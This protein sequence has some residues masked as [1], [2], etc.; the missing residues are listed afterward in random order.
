M[1]TFAS[2]ILSLLDS[3]LINSLS[4]GIHETKRRGF[5]KTSAASALGTP[6][7]IFPFP[8][9]QKDWGVRI[10]LMPVTF[11]HRFLPIAPPM[12]STRSLLVHR[13]FP[14]AVGGLHYGG[15][16]APAWGMNLERFAR[17]L[18]RDGAPND[19]SVDFR[20][21]VSRRDASFFPI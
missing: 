10:Q 12:S 7:D 9:S 21:G 3:E 6:V 4:L 5:P 18:L 11:H 8:P 13:S 19:A 14:S 15:R 1:E 20:K 17:S 2:K 16:N